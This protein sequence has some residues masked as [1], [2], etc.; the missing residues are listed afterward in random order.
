MAHAEAEAPAGEAIERFYRLAKRQAWAVEDLPWGEL[1]PIPES[2]GARRRDVWRSVLT[3]QLQA[4]RLAAEL[5]AQLLGAAPHLDAKLYYCAMLDDEVRHCDAWTQLLHAAGGEAE[6]DPH[7]AQLGR[8]T[9]DADTIEEKVFLLQA[10]YE[11][12]VIPR[13]RLLARSARGTVLEHL[14]TRLA[15]DDGVHHGAGLAYERVL[16]ED[17]SPRLKGCVV[18]SARRMLPIFVRHM[19]WRP[20][21]RRTVG[22]AMRPRDVARIRAHVDEGRRIAASLGLEVGELELVL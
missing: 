4:D 13:L 17:A 22:G 5:S 9:L 18:E 2:E 10:F 3:Q 21:A 20:S 6:H 1:P 15:I 14:C 11:G 12:L 16:L 8:L 7:L 19:L